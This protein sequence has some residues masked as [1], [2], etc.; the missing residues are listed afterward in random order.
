M[1]RNS[2]L[3]RETPLF[4]E[5]LAAASNSTPADAEEHFQ[6]MVDDHDHHEEGSIL[7]DFLTE[8]SI[9]EFGGERDE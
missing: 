2:R 6:A 1:S 4:A 8:Y 3:Q 9:S 5:A 7:T